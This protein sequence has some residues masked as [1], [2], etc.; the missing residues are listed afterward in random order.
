MCN[1]SHNVSFRADDDQPCPNCGTVVE[2]FEE[3]SRYEG[4]ECRDCDV[5][6]SYEEWADGVEKRPDPDPQHQVSD[7]E[8]RHIK[9]AYEDI[10]TAIEEGRFEVETP[11][12]HA[13][14]DTFEQVNIAI[15]RD[16]EH[17]HFNDTRTSPPYLTV[18]LEWDALDDEDWLLWK[19]LRAHGAIEGPCILYGQMHL[20]RMEKQR[21]KNVES[22]VPIDGQARCNVEFEWHRVEPIGW[23]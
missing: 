3:A 23:R 13:S 5:H 4:Y 2:E 1:D 6:W 20:W 15:E 8:I 7:L 19:D 21:G 18:E 10:H 9:H 12:V 16:V 22:S 14:K 11:R 17:L